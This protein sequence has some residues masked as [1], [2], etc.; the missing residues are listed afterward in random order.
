MKKT[1]LSFVAFV[2][3]TVCWGQQQLV[4]TLT[5]GEEISMFYG[6]YAYRDAMNAAVDGDVINLSGGGFQATTINKAVSIRGAGVDSAYPT[7]IINDFNINVPEESTGRLAIEGV[8]I[9][10]TI[11]VNGTLTNAYFLKSSIEK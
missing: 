4:A 5:H 6:T 1:I 10:N 8:R 2:F 7:F 11:T 3:A 9:S